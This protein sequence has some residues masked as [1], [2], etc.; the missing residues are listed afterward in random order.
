MFHWDLHF[1]NFLSHLVI[2]TLFYLFIDESA[3]GLVIEEENLESSEGSEY[4]LNVLMA[5]CS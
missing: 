3:F 2:L 1:W 5:A 4:P